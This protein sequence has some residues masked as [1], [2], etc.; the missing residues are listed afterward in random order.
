MFLTKEAD[1]LL[2]FLRWIASKHHDGGAIVGRP[3][4]MN[5]FKRNGIQYM[6]EEELDGIINELEESGCVMIDRDFSP[7]SD[8]YWLVDKSISDIIIKIKKAVENYS[9]DFKRTIMIVTPLEYDRVKFEFQSILS[10][11]GMSFCCAQVSYILETNKL[12]TSPNY[13]QFDYPVYVINA[14]LD[15]QKQMY[16]AIREDLEASEYQTIPEQDSNIVTFEKKKIINPEK[17]VKKKI[18]KVKQVK[19]T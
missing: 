4:L 2:T 1:S 6:S 10:V 19:K 14:L 9:N 18:K 16:I 3:A 12:L 15:A 11:S 8:K 7:T 5:H 13:Y 17:H